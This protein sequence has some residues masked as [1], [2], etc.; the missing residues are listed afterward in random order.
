VLCLLDLVDE[1]NFTENLEE[2]TE[3]NSVE[4]VRNDNELLLAEVDDMSNGKNV[5]DDDEKKNWIV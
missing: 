3:G 2:I 1:N 4:I 5:K